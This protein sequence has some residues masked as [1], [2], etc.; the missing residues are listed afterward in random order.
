[1]HFII[2]NNIDLDGSFQSN[3]IVGHT[4][5]GI[6][7]AQSQLLSSIRT[8]VT[9][10]AGKEMA[11]SL[12]IID[13]HSFSQVS[14]PIIDT[15]LLYRLETDPHSIHVYQ[16]KSSIMPGNLWGEKIKIDFN[17]IK[18]FTLVEYD[19]VSAPPPPPFRSQSE[20]ELSIKSGL[21]DS[22]SPSKTSD[23]LR[24]SPKGKSDISVDLIQ[25]L[26]S[27]PVFKK[28]FEESN[29]SNR[30]SGS[31][32]SPT[33]II[34]SPPRKIIMMPH[35]PLSVSAPMLTVVEELR[36]EIST[37]LEISTT[38]EICQTPD[39]LVTEDLSQTP[40]VESLSELM[41]SEA[42]ETLSTQ[43]VLELSTSEPSCT[44]N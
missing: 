33:R 3:E 31:P 34:N 37:D 39:V 44:S 30:S 25:S 24:S 9:E 26:K 19:R 6:A 8:Y 13:I 4:T 27:S 1:M 35:S 5:T 29:G 28:K 18:I 23:N 42:L 17:K 22:S 21:T 40:D 10:L 32:L 15:L 12:K 41:M 20:R 14:E 38:E 11:N 16:R 43:F 2:K 36:E 7:S